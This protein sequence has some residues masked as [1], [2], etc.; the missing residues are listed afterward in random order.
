MASAD[1]GLV[2]TQCKTFGHCTQKI[3]YFSDLKY[4]VPLIGKNIS[5]DVAIKG[6]TSETLF[7]TLL[8]IRIFN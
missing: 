5:V 2:E 4:F 7:L 3:K 6:R 8:L 1:S